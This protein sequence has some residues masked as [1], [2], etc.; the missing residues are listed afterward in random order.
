MFSMT[1]TLLEHCNIIPAP[2][3]PIGLLLLPPGLPPGRLPGRL[4]MEGLRLLYLSSGITTVGLLR[5][6][7]RCLGYITALGFGFL[8][9][10]PLVPVLRVGD[11]ESADGNPEEPFGLL[12]YIRRG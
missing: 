12:K 10:D 7:D 9:L 5:G 11:F 6:E 3:L 1:V 8:L 2:S 4:L